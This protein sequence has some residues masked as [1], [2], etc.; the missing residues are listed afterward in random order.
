MLFYVGRK[1]I[2]RPSKIVIKKDSDITINVNRVPISYPFYTYRKVIDEFRKS[3]KVCMDRPAV[4]LLDFQTVIIYACIV[5]HSVTFI[6]AKSY[7][8]Y[9]THRTSNELISEYLTIYMYRT[10]YQNTNYI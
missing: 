1:D 8:I 4:S 6:S 9:S 7:S 5:L 10:R 2:H 3:N